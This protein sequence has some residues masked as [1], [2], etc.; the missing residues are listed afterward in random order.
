MGCSFPHLQLQSFFC[1]PHTSSHQ[2]LMPARPLP[3]RTQTHPKTVRFAYKNFFY[4]PQNPVATSPAHIP[5]PSIGYG[6]PHALPYP[7][8][9][10]SVHAHPLLDASAITYDVMEHPSTITTLNNYSL[11]TR[12]LREQ[13]TTP[14]LPFL[15]ITSIHLPWS[16]KVYASN[17][18][19]VT[20]EDVFDSIYR[21]LRTNITNAEF[22]MFS[23][24]D[25]QRRATRA[26]EKRYRRLRNTRAY[27]EEK[28]GGMKRVDFLMNH[29]RF[30]SI[31]NSSR[32]PDEWQLRVA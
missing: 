24:Q 15:R 28:R 14:P 31:S 20:L 30:L 3:A 17:G 32:L 12:T 19:F 10:T 27:E 16:I 29:T 2:R 9:T 18:L 26:Y 8:S 13:A 7:P 6:L 11:S 23:T 21:T 1:I 5:P 4:S 22:N 25:D